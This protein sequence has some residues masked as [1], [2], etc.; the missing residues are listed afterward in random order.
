MQETT[1]RVDLL[2]KYLKGTI[3]PDN[4]IE[5]KKLF[6]EYPDLFDLVHRLEDP[7][8][9]QQA[10][11][12]Y[13]YFHSAHTVHHKEQTLQNI[14]HRIEEG[15]KQGVRS[16]TYRALLRYTAAASILAIL[17]M[18]IWYLLSR[19]NLNPDLQAL[20]EAEKL[21]PGSNRATLLAA[22]GSVIE[23]NASQSGIVIGDQITYNDGSL[24]LKDI[25]EETVQLTLSTPKGGQYHVTLPDG[26]K[27]WLNADSRLKY[28]NRFTAPLREVELDGEAYFEVTSN[29]KQ[30]F[31]VKTPN[32][33]VE[34]LGT[35]FNI[36]S[37]RNEEASK[38]ALLE[39]KVRVV[40][41]N[42]QSS[43]LHPGQQTFFSNNQMAI[44]NINAEESI[45]WKNGEFTFN[46]ESL[47]S[48]MR[49][50]ARWYDIEIEVDPSLKQLALWG[51]VS[52]LDNFDK[53]LKIIKMTDD[54]IKI[55][56]EGRRVKI[57]R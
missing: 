9:L 27:V 53:V 48:A 5:L 7:S 34:V 20:K 46:N 42:R 41:D 2:K 23:L 55:R 16:G 18:G 30:P 43:T 1:Y 37:Y 21:S 39:G 24:L 3:H 56:I 31:I 38:V 28:P 47:G 22:D 51:S 8:H 14:L 29:P 11:Q 19:P 35:H 50:V 57:M 44:Q 26:S 40:A 36:N 17:S 54:N 13:R 12:E 10:L 15:P 33:Q 4:H 45:A 6:E 52:R 25:Q 49:Q 32:E